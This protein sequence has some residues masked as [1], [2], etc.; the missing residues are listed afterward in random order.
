VVEDH[1]ERRL[2]VGGDTL[3]VYPLDGDW[4]RFHREYWWHAVVAV[5]LPPRPTVLLVGLGGGTQIHLLRRL[6]HPRR[7]T[8]IERDEAILRVARDWFGLDRVGRLEFLCTEA[9]VAVQALAG[10]GRRFDYIM[11][12][13]A[14]ADDPEDAVPLARALAPLVTPAGTLVLNRHRRADATSL[15]KEMRARFENVAVRRVR[16]EGENA[17]VIC[18]G[19]RDRG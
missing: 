4:S 16:R 5:T 9:D 18:T 11:E 14:Y 17:L 15:T 3:S 7:I 12:D 8:A 6:A 2:I 1:V 19:P 13:A 10:A